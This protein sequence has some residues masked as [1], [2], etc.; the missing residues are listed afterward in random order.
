MHYIFSFLFAVFLLFCPVGAIAGAI[1]GEEIAKLWDNRDD[2]DT[3][4]SKSRFIL[5]NKR[6]QQRVRQTI[7]YWKDE[8]G[9]DGFEEK[10]VIFFLSPPDIRKT[11]F[12]N[13]S[14]ADINKDDDQWLYLPALK[15]VK[16]IASDN[17][18]D[19]FMGTDLTYDDMGDRKIE[20]DI[21][22]G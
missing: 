20:E 10:S 12:L 2:G 22:G 15:K 17:K 5:E 14:Y 16:R 4:I 1:T 8:D 6:G 18:D 19:Y 7:R 13:W 21:V 11:A 9:K 3:S